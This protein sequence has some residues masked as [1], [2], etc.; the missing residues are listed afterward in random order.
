MNVDFDGPLFINTD[1]FLTA[2]VNYDPSL[3]IPSSELSPQSF[4][5]S[6]TFQLSTQTLFKHRNL[7][8]H[9][10]EFPTA[11]S[12]IDKTIYL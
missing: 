11:N 5:P 7:S 1:P 9:F 8:S 2:P 3:F 12:E 4:T 10:V 6:L